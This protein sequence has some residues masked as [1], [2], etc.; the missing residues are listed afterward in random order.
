MFYGRLLL[1]ATEPGEWRVAQ[2]FTWA[3]ERYH[4][5][6]PAGFITDLASIPSIFRGIFDRNGESRKAAVFHDWLYCSKEL[7][8]RAVVDRLFYQA[9]LH[10]KAGQVE[11][12]MMYKAVRLGGWMY[13]NKRKD[14]LTREDWQL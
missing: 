12:W 4:V 9:L 1:E 5:M 13:W 7:E 8:D 10:E 14:G 6:I 2:P 11:A 3:D